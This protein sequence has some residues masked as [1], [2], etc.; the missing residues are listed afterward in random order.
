[1]AH[2]RKNMTTN[3]NKQPWLL[4]WN[5]DGAG[6]ALVGPFSSQDAAA[7]WA[8]NPLNNPRDEP[9]WQVVDLTEPV[10]AFV[11]PPGPEAQA[12]LQRLWRKWE[13]VVVKFRAS[14]PYTRSR[15]W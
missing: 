3:G 11:C 9:C 12:A 1:V 7:G 10:P 15:T 14:P 13:A 2:R 8:T 5:G 4:I 6:Y